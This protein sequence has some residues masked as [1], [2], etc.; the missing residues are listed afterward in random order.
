MKKSLCYL[1][2]LLTF[3]INSSCSSNST[4][5]GDAIFRATINGELWEATLFSD[6]DGLYQ[7]MAAD[8]Q[9]L[10]ILGTDDNIRLRIV[11]TTFGISDCM[12]SGNYDFPNRIDISYGYP[13]DAWVGGHFYDEDM[14]GNKIMTLNVTSCSENKISG[15]FSGSYTGDSGPDSPTNI[16]ITDGVFENIEFP[17]YQN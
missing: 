14:N 16:V 11:L 9:L 7:I 8:E 4:S 13:G 10:Q 3:T 6:T 2:V 15:T 5:D 12:P 1:M 17:I